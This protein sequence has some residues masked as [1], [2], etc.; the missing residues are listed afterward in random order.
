M[1]ILV[2]KPSS[3]GDIIHALPF[4]KAVKDTFPHA[5]IDWVIS[6]NFKGILE[7]NPLINELIIFN[8]D[9]WKSVRKL[10]DTVSDISSLRKKLQSKH[11]DMVVDLQGLLRSGLIGF[12]TTAT[13]K[14]GFADAREG[15]RCV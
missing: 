6:R 14:V 9:T 15:F 13:E 2:I 3:L 7:D 5:V 12:F 8:K 1:K 4:L 11:Y 10:P